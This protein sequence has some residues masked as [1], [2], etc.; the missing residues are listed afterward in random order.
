VAENENAAIPAT[1][2]GQARPAR[3]CGRVF[4]VRP[5]AQPG[6][7]AIVDERADRLMWTPSASRRAS[8]AGEAADATPRA[9]G[10]AGGAGLQH[11]TA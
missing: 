4:S 10:G 5:L 9:D 3:A 7:T 2:A 1:T 6:S 11:L 8:H